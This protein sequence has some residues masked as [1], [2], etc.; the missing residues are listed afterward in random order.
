ME[1]KLTRHVKILGAKLRDANESVL[2]GHLRPQ[3]WLGKPPE[4]YSPGSPQEMQLV[5]NYGYQAWWQTQGALELLENAR[6]NA[7]KDSA[8]EIE[9]MIREGE[10]RTPAEFLDDVSL[11]R[12]WGYFDW[13]VEDATSLASERP[14]D[15]A[16]QDQPGALEV[17][18]GGR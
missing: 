4:V 16:S 2:D 12:I 11:N 1:V 15:V 13:A 10:T 6:K 9:D 14:S 3:P 7:E 5:L 8:E 17:C 18:Y